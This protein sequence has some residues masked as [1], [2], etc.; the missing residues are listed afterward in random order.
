MKQPRVMAPFAEGT[1]QRALLERRLKSPTVWDAFLAF[2]DRKGHQV[3]GE[4]LDREV[5]EPVAASEAVQDRL[6]EIYAEDHGLADF[7][8]LMTDLDEGL[9]EWRY[10]HVKMVERTIGNKTGTGGS[11]GVDYLKS[12]LF[13][14]F[15]PDLWA[16]RSKIG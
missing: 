15:F 12:T 4:I 1:P 14:S 7:C 6:Q 2:V 9:Q 11:S 16:F 13:K 3:P 10:R 8:E 5:E